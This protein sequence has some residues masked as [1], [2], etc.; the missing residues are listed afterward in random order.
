MHVLTEVQFQVVA[1]AVDGTLVSFLVQWFLL[2]KVV[3]AHFERVKL[4]LRLTHLLWSA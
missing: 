3:A 2:R 1:G 4:V